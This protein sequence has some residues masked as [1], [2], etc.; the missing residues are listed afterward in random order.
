MATRRSR[1]A[2]PEL[3]SSWP[4]ATITG[5]RV[6]PDHCRRRPALEQDPVR[7]GALI[8]SV[9]APH[10]HDLHRL[11][12]RR[13]FPGLASAIASIFSPALATP[14]DRHAPPSPLPASAAQAPPFKVEP[15]ALRAQPEPQQEVRR[16]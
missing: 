7:P 2:P 4:P 10:G 11:G 9:Y 14:L 6:A 12:R 13:Q 15:L 8:N 1:K 16:Q 3:T 5:G